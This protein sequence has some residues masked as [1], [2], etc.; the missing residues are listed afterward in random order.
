MNADTAI[1]QRVGR[2][3][4]LADVLAA[5]ARIDPVVPG[6]VATAVAAGCVLAADVIA[7]RSRPSA[8]L[9]LRDGW[10][11]S[12]DLTR[13][14]GPYAPLTLQPPPQRIDTFTALPPGTDAVAPLDAVSAL[15][16]MTQIM[17]PA[18]PGE[19]V[20]PSGGDVEANAVLC[21]AGTRLRTSDV[22]VLIA[23]GVDA[24]A[25][26]QP[27]IGIV[28]TKHNDKLL[29]AAA[30]FVAD[31]CRAAGAKA[32]VRSALDDAFHRGDADALIAIG[33]TGEGRH[34]CSVMA[35]SR[36][37]TVICHGIG[38]TPGDTAAFGMAKDRPVLIMPGR[39]DA[40]LACW[41][42]LGRAL[43]DRLSGADDVEIVGKVTLARKVTSTVG[44]AEVVPLR[45]VG[46]RVEPLASGY[47]PLQSLAR[48]DGWM[49]VPAESE[50]YPA[51]A[52][53]E[54]RPL[55]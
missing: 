52:T 21:R 53:I 32:D 39:I 35:L 1:Q 44:I 17:T 6:E 23:A 40:V 10:A 5:I 30:S 29:E 4:P 34:D 37:G 42:V 27:R 11:V 16:G 50:G 22:A 24:V 54:M 38:L 7:P 25:I 47:L 9:A 46:E 28:T 41:L 49:L 14:A 48:A 45:R 15:G 26:R 33:G 55:P 13:D 51:G 43:L 36:A 18:A 31:A 2:L 8:A 12:S 3:T 19:S 20:L